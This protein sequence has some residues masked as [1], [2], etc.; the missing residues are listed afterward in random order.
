MITEERERENKRKHKNYTNSIE[1]LYSIR[2]GTD[3]IIERGR[4]ISYF[5]Y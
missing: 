3:R 4:K 1:L 5:N 2:D